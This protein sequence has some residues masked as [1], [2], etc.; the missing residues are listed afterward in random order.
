MGADP[1]YTS[2]EQE[3]ANSLAEANKT[4]DQ[5]A[6]ERA[7]MTTGQTDLA[8]QWRE[9]QDSATQQQT[10]FQVDL[11]E[12]QRAL[13]QKDYTKENTAAHADYTKATDQ[14]GVNAERMASQGFSGSGVSE[15]GRVSMFNAMQQRVAIA[16]DGFGRATLNYDNTIKEARMN[17]NVKMAENALA[18]L[19]RQLD[20]AAQ[21][22]IYK[23]SLNR[24]RLSNTQNIDDRYYNR[25]QNIYN[26]ITQEQQSAEE[27]RRYNEQFNYQKTQ[28]QQAQSN[29]LA[30]FNQS[31]KASSSGGG[32][33]KPIVKEKDPPVITDKGRGVHMD[34]YGVTYAIDTRNN[35][36]VRLD[37]QEY[38]DMLASYR[39]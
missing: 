14:F 38:K 11:T 16:R 17:G 4:Y 34:Q 36:Y 39:R 8:N 35:T 18:L 2:I 22:F 26:Q 33:Y 24:E 25:T 27:L 30:Q 32:G 3:K 1:R 6:A 28:D 21:A 37:S 23:D 5:L 20:I 29:W 15:S 31:K 13:A 7:A 10:Q 19:E 9:Q 12:Q